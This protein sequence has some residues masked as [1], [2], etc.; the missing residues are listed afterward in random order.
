[1]PELQGA[2]STATSWTAL[3]KANRLRSA[4]SMQD[5]NESKSFWRE[6]IEACGKRFTPGLVL[7]DHDTLVPFGEQLHAAPIS[8][9]W[10]AAPSAFSRTQAAM[11][12]TTLH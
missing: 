2:K 10:Q 8:A 1:M 5:L 11:S 12:N 7:Y 3:Y 6:L 4:M 9:L